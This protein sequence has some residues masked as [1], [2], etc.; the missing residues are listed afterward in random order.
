M[1]QTKLFDITKTYLRL[2][3]FQLSTKKTAYSFINSSEATLSYN[4]L[5]IKVIPPSENYTY[6]GLPINLNLDWEKTLEEDRKSL[7]NTLN[8]FSSKSYLDTNI[9]IKLINAVAIPKIA[10]KWNFILPPTNY[11]EALD[12]SVLT[13]LKKKARIGRSPEQHWSLYRDLILPSSKAP[14]CY[15]SSKITRG[16]NST[17]IS[18]SSALRFSLIAKSPEKYLL[19]SVHK[20]LKQFN[21]ALTNPPK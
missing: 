9:T 20:V 8:Y 4:N 16:L 6:L 13:V 21:L 10:Y 18:T 2:T 19:P 12:K 17:S 5:P 15:L 1:Q 14:Q 7:I 11:L 3:N